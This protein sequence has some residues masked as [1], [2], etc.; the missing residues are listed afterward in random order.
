MT[1]TR[2]RNKIKK[3]IKNINIKN[4]I[5][6]KVFYYYHKP[7]YQQLNNLLFDYFFYFDQHPQILYYLS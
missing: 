1:K 5:K 2:E 6:I 7:N 3:E 4:Q